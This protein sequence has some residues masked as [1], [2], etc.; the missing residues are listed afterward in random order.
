MAMKLVIA[1]E[2]SRVGAMLISSAQTLPSARRLVIIPAHIRPPVGAPKVLVER[3]WRSLAQKV[4]GL[5]GR[6]VSTTSSKPGVLFVDDEPDFLAAIARNLR[7]SPFRITTATDGNSALDLLQK[8][9]YAVS[10][11]TFGCPE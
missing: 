2:E 7:S 4:V 1:P 10:S 5:G 9:P 8:G 11:R 6:T 3:H